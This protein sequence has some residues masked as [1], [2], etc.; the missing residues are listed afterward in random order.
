MT[1][2][3]VATAGI[4]PCCY[5]RCDDGT[6]NPHL[7]HLG[8]CEP[9]QRRYGRV[10]DWLAMDYVTLRTQLPAP[11]GRGQE[12]VSGSSREPGHP[13][14]WASDTAALIAAVL[15]DVEDGLREH[16]GD[17]P[18]P[19]PGSSEPGR[20]AH[21]HRYLSPRVDKL[22][23][24]PGAEATATELTALHGRIRGALGQTR[25]RQPVAAPCPDCDLLTLYRTVD[26]ST[27]D[28]IE[29][30]HCGRTI[31]EQQYGLYARIVLDEALEAA[32]RPCPA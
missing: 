26:R 17:D 25:H 9:C 16:L 10:L 23:E 12:P 6:G 22:A 1:V 14:E 2:S 19:H 20:V 15:N 18:P 28:Q 24:Y 4:R 30:E 29:C 11:T 32:E 3:T 31:T 27:V 5:P 8:I 21:A 7:T 13:A